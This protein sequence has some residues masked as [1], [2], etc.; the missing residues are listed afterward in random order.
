M[1]SLP[2]ETST[3]DG[4]FNFRDLGGM[5]A[6]GG[7]IRHGV[8]Y[9]SDAFGGL[10]PE[11][12]AQLAAS[13][14]GTVVDFRTPAER[15]MAPDRLPT[16]R[17]ITLIELPM[18]Q[19]EAQGAAKAAGASDS[20]TSTPD[21]A[22]AAAAAQAA[23]ASLPTLPEMYVG[24]L[25]SGGAAF[26]RVA[27]LIAAETP[28]APHDAVVLHCTAGKD[29]TGV[30]TALMLLAAGADRD[31]VVA[32]YA[33]S[34]ANLAG[35]WADRMIGMV[36]KMGATVTP[37]LREVITG[38]P[39]SAIETALAWVDANHGSAAGYLAASGVDAATLAALRDRLV[40]PAA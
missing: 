33:S 20:A 16:E 12:L 29:R 8:L 26:A 21:R 34:A 27:E 36:E 28:G 13:P 10:T 24:M 23:I 3:L 18:L 38:T 32:D 2:T 11:G 7:S 9:R 31:A 14:I 1:T 17:A 37:A 39:P 25:K 22:A 5:P 15:Q 4:T 30:S 6:A 35:P 40:E 19:G